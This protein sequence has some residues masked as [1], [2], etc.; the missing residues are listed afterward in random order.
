MDL[1]WIV[2]FVALCACTGAL[3]WACA[4]LLQPAAPTRH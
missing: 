1:V 3:V 4:A 2:A